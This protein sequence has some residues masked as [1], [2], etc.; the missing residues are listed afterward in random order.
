MKY[1][2]D[3]VFYAS[4]PFVPHWNSHNEEGERCILCQVKRRRDLVE[5]ENPESGC[6]EM[7][8]RRGG[9]DSGFSL[10]GGL[11][12]GLAFWN[13]RRSIQGAVDIKRRCLQSASWGPALDST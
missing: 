2:S 11:G 7:E 5:K 3:G 4:F 9:V 8:G 10:T 13:I 12:E 1:F 6:C